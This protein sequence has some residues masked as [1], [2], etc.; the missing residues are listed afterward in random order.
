MGCWFNLFFSYPSHIQHPTSS[1]LSDNGSIITCNTHDRQVRDLRKFYEL[2]VPKAEADVLCTGI[3]TLSGNVSLFLSD[4]TDDTT[5][6]Y[7][8]GKTLTYREYHPFSQY[9][10][11]IME[12]DSP[13]PVYTTAGPD[14][15]LARFVYTEESQGGCLGSRASTRQVAHITTSYGRGG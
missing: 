6:T 10:C 12:N 14:G 5:K 15:S 7:G 13:Y 3:W 1:S 8:N 11:H 4:G 2:L 9:D